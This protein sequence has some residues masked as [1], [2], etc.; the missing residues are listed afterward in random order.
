VLAEDQKD[1]KQSSAHSGAPPHHTWPA[2][3]MLA[4]ARM[5]IV[6]MIAFNVRVS[7]IAKNEV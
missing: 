4:V 6:L 3:A 2:E 1:E 7:L 5:A